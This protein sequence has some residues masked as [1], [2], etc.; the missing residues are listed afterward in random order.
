MAFVRH[1][2]VSGLLFVRFQRNIN[3]CNRTISFPLATLASSGKDETFKSLSDIPGPVSL[4]VVGTAWRFFVGGRGEP[5]GKRLLSSQKESVDKYGPIFKQ[6]FGGNISV[7][8]TDPSDVAKVLRN[9]S[10]YP[11]RLRAPVLD[12]YRE[13]RQ[14]IPG[15]FFADGPEWYKHRSVLSKRMLRPKQVADYACGFNEIITDFIR[16]LRTIREPVD[17]EKANEVCGLDNELFKWSFES[18]AEMLFDKRFGCLEPQVNKEA[19]IFI[20]AVGDFLYNATAIGFLPAWFYKIY[21]TGQFK[22]FCDNFDIMHDYAEMFIQRRVN[23]LED[24]SRISSKR[25]DDKAGFFE[26]LLSSGKLTKDDLLASVIDVL[27]AGVDTTSNTM[28]WI[29]YMM[30]KNP[31]KQV[32][33]RQE[34][35]SV[36]GNNTTATP[37]TLAEMPYLKAWVRETLRLY[38]VLPVTF[39]ILPTDT[40]LSGYHIPAG[41]QVTSLAY[42]MSRDESIFTNAH[43]FKPERWLRDNN[44]DS[45]FID[46]KEVFSSIPFGFGTRM[47]LGRRIAELELHLLLARIVQ[48]F[49]ISYPPGVEEVEPFVRGVTIPDRPVRVKFVDRKK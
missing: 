36:L 32:I 14:R 2:K 43:E 46:A 11:Q 33:L 47:C 37:T 23:V 31:D 34:V 9:E 44:Q 26:F 3:N 40:N 49:D 16:R 48:Q 18:V 17:S 12:Y 13:M 30:A 20:K 6:K 7:S 28:Q 4:P 19:Q 25:D 15:V 38:P 45:K 8:L 42:F 29:L 1:S 41:T 22:K 21:K 39:R 35:L 27:F 24:K 5:L 10:K